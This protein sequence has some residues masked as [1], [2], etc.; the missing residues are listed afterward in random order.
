MMKHTTPLPVNRFPVGMPLPVGS[1]HWMT[2]QDLVARMGRNRSP[3]PESFS[4]KRSADITGS[5][6]P[7]IV[8]IRLVAAALHWQQERRTLTGERSW[9]S[10]YCLIITEILTQTQRLDRKGVDYGYYRKDIGF[11]RMI[12]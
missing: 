12:K 4:M 11:F 8:T 6:G 5:I 1:C 10:W 7:C 3:L 2:W 9:P